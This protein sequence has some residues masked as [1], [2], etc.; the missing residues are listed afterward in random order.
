[1]ADP[2]PIFFA[3][4]SQAYLF[5]KPGLTLSKLEYYAEVLAMQPPLIQ[6]QVK[7][8]GNHVTAGCPCNPPPQ[9][10]AQLLQHGYFFTAVK[11]V[12]NDFELLKV[13]GREGERVDRNERMCYPLCTNDLC[14]R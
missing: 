5:S 6:L 13:R 2:L 1:M 14:L 11:V 7:N 3:S 8:L 10:A 4:E 9:A 12:Y